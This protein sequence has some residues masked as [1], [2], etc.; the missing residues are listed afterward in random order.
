MNPQ[1]AAVA[2]NKSETL[3]LECLITD[4]W[5]YP[6]VKH[7]SDEDQGLEFGDVNKSNL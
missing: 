6:N 1:T 3:K 4:G 2:E 5:K 7:N